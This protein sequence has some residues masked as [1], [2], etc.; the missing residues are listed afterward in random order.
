MIFEVLKIVHF[1]LHQSKKASMGIF[2]ELL[3]QSEI[4]KQSDKSKSLEDRITSLEND[5]DNTKKLLQ[6]TLEALENHL[7]KDI[8]GDGITGN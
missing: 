8:D 2:W 6:K 3:Q 1:E 7:Q 4:Q 5:L